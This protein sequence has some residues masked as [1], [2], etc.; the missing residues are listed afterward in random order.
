M[1]A[2]NV[3]NTSSFA[4][5]HSYSDRSG[6]PVSL[7]LGLVVV[8]LPRSRTALGTRLLRMRQPPRPQGLGCALQLIDMVWGKLKHPTHE[9]IVDHF[10]YLGPPPGRQL[11][12]EEVAAVLEQVPRRPQDFRLRDREVGR[13][14]RL[15]LED[16]SA[17]RAA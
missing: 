5:A 11:L 16:A 13:L 1:A 12:V 4:T 7:C 17:I 2:S 3:S 9:H 14:A 8:Q 10:D 6:A 15:H